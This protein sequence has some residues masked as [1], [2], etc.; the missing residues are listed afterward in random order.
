MSDFTRLAGQ[1]C[2]PQE[3]LAMELAVELGAGHGVAAARRSLSL[4]ARMLPDIAEPA[5]QLDALREVAFRTLRPR[6]D[7]QYLLPATT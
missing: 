4:L 6:S 3:A 1:Q 7:G 2:P 5:A